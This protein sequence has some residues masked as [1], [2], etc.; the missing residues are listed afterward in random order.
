MLT[1]AM[2]IDRA[3]AGEALGAALPTFFPP[4]QVS[5]T[6]GRA[7][8]TAGRPWSGRGRSKMKSAHLPGSSAPILSS[9]KPA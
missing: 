8:A 6:C 3:Q 5:S 1:P 2:L 7:Q 4:T 9:A